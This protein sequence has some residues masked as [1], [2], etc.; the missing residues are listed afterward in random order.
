MISGIEQNPKLGFY[1]V[2]EETISL[3]PQALIRATE[4]G[5]YPTWHFNN[6]I[7]ASLNWT[8]EPEVDIRELYRIRAQQLRDKYD[9]IRVEASGGGDSTTAIYSFLLNDIHLDEVVFRYPKGLDKGL[10]GDAQNYHAENTLSEREF[11]AEPLLRWIRTNYPK[12]KVT[13]QDYAENLFTGDYL[14]KDESWVFNTR[15]YFQP[16]HGIKHNNF[17]TR[18]HRLLADSGKKICALYGVDKPKISLLDGSWYASFIDLQAN[19]GAPIVEDYTNITTELF[20]WSPDLPELSVKQAHLVK[21]WFDIPH[22]INLRHL[23]RWPNHGIA[24]RSAY[25]QIIKPIIYPDYDP[26]TWQTTKPTN[27]FYN[28]MDHWFHAN[29]KGTSL[30]NTWEAGIEFLKNKIDHKYLVHEC[31][32]PVGL[33]GFVSPLY[34]LGKSTAPVSQPAFVNQSY[35][36]DDRNRG[37]ILAVVDKKL[38]K[39]QL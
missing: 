23:V 13:V 14:N 22:N 24:Q 3:K 32:K 6:K 26:E 27:N 5:H 10:T 16:A 19:H 15:E 17:N 4:T 29:L 11:A 18:E 30:Y 36:A 34:Y 33:I 12:V 38:K 1:R 2:G 28:E 25:E 31:G 37:N 7:Y 21:N 39:I 9:W 35:K 20:Y 8:E